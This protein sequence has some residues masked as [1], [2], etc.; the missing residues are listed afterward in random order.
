MM[1]WYDPSH[2]TDADT[3]IDAAIASF[4]EENLAIK[5]ERAE[6]GMSEMRDWLT[7]ESRGVVPLYQLPCQD[8]SLYQAD[9]QPYHHPPHHLQGQGPVPASL[10]LPVPVPV[11]VPAP[12]P[13]PGE[14]PRTCCAN[15]G[16]H[17]T[18]LW[19][20]D[21]SGAPVCNACGLYYKLHGKK[22]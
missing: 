19:R 5:T 12:G 20:R 14:V 9:T 16:T 7:E 22:R 6:V 3:G 15:C 18:S 8:T 17:Q 1:Q 11:P 4:Y 2:M 21:A 10:P 13:E